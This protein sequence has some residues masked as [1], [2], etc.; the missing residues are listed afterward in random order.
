MNTAFEKYERRTRLDIR[1]S[2]RD[3]KARKETPRTESVDLDRHAART[4]TIESMGLHSKDKLYR[5]FQ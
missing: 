1:A 4:F 5:V 2:N 3:S